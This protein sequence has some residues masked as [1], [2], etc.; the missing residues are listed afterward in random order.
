LKKLLRRTDSNTK[1]T[2][3]R[4]KIA[5]IERQNAHGL[6]QPLGIDSNLQHQ[7]VIGVSQLWSP[8]KLDGNPLHHT[9]KHIQEIHNILLTQPR[10]SQ[11]L[12]AQQDIFILQKQRHAAHHRYLPLQYLAQYLCRCTAWTA[13]ARY[14]HIGIQYVFHIA[15]NI[16]Q[17]QNHR[18]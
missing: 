13:H 17:P 18:R 8:Q 15:G 9:R 12:W 3:L 2:C 6:P 4:Q 1:Q 14:Q 16:Q 7:V 5:L 11:L 10:R